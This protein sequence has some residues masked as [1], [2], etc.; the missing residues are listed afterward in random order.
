MNL[1]RP[2]SFET[3][4]V[5]RRASLSSISPASANEKSNVQIGSS[6][7][8]PTDGSELPNLP[9][10]DDT[11][12][13]KLFLTLPAE[14]RL[15]IWGYSLL[16]VRVVE[17]RWNPES[18]KY[19]T[20]VVQPV[21]LHVCHE[22]REVALKEYDLLELPC[23]MDPV[24]EL[25][26][27]SNNTPLRPFGTYINFDRDELVV[28]PFL[29]GSTTARVFFA[30]CLRAE[31]SVRGKLKRISIGGHVVSRT[32]VSEMRRFAMLISRMWNVST[33]GVVEVK[34]GDWKST[35]PPSDQY[36]MQSGFWFRDTWQRPHPRSM[37]YTVGCLKS[38]FRYLLSAKKLLDELPKQ[39]DVE[40]KYQ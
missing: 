32:G 15:K 29:I 5:A 6:E 16:G 17:V 11:A 14:L 37:T 27:R 8:S 1:T 23:I 4:A 30:I 20:T 28:A 35:A 24:M 33:V 2:G 21:I 39:R 31:E 3:R 9:D 25:A 34:M 13:F 7:D 26:L 40:F 36:S 18:H 22:S 19:Y 10:E 12:E 38:E